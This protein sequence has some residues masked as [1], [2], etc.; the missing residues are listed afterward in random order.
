MLNLQL[1]NP[2]IEDWASKCM[3]DLKELNINLSFAEIKS[4]TKIK[5]TNILKEEM[6]KNAFKYWKKKRGKKGEGIDYSCIKM[7]EY[8]QP[9]NTNLTVEQKC[10]MFAVRNIIF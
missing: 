8:L 4:I 5:F 3:N 1:E 2:T 9:T 10:E 6:K 7:S